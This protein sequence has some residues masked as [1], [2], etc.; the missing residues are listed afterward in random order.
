[1]RLKRLEITGFK[2]FARKSVFEF[3]AAVSSIVGPNGSGKS[4]VAES[5]RFVLGEQSMKSLRGKRGEDLIWN[6][7]GSMARG[8]VASVAIVFDNSTKEF[9]MDYDEVEIKRQVFRDGTN[10][11]FINGTQVRLKDILELLA[12]VHIGATGHHIISQGEADR[13][14]NANIKER[15]TMIEDA[16][17]LKIYQWKIEESEKKL[18]K[19]EEN[20]KQVESLRREIAPHIRFLKK[21]VEKIE[22]AKEMRDEL[23]ELYAEYLKREDV[24]INAE[25]ERIKL[26]KS[27][28]VSS[29]SVI[30]EKLNKA[31]AVLAAS[32]EHD[33]KKDELLRLE[34]EISAAR[35]G[36]DDAAR[37]ANR[38]DGMI[39]FE[40]RRLEKTRSR[41]AEAKFVSYTD[42]RSFTD[43]VEEFLKEGEKSDTLSEAR[44][45]FVK[46]RR[47]LGDFL[48]RVRQAGGGEPIADFSELSALKNEKK[49][50]E[51]SLVTATENES[52]LK[53]CYT[54]L[55]ESIEREKDSS[56][57]TER[58]VFEMMA[59]KS[60][61]SAVVSRLKDTE[62]N[63]EKA[64]RALK[65]EIKEGIVLVGRDIALY[66]NF[67]VS[68]DAVTGEPREEQEKRRRV[69]ERI[70]IKLEEQ[71][72]GGG[73]DIL[74]EYNDATERDGFLER[75]ITD[76]YQ[77]AESLRALIA[78]LNERLDTDFKE[79]IG[80]INKQFQEFF[81]LMFGG[82]T[83]S[84]FVVAQK[85][86]KRRD[87]DI[88]LKDDDEIVESFEEEI[89]E[90]IDINVSLPR[91]KIKGLQMLSGGERALTSIALIFAVSQVNPPPFL[92]LDETD[93]ALD[94]AN[95]RRYGDM[96]E[97]LSKHSQL[98]VITHNRETMSRAG[99]LYGVTMGSDA[100]S[101]LLS[102]RFD[103]A[104][105]FAK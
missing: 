15:R 89:E 58:A 83:A 35:A 61:L 11:Y 8:N 80:K 62:E 105:Q 26:E 81:A 85:K 34:S 65:E 66:E 63:I 79:G 72:V 95:S 51:E 28:P 17:G 39:E 90:G 43:E 68:R 73:E 42:V 88:V 1:M 76:L 40:E 96:L 50:A 12:K 49:K 3:N 23:K 13:I 67:A 31:R 70:K 74:K 64:D 46:A 84:L 59:K 56:R 45:F 25:K 52:R 57:E 14:L 55:K 103:E 102:V 97:N 30:E 54:A 93:A 38:L 32:D 36:K 33:P 94:E 21:Q 92:V 16:L 104:A 41:E 48:I 44:A 86:R 10:Q 2:S 6:G 9:E 37:Q 4:N 101:K 18:G 7:S 75:E 78:E 29:L 47:V 99:L 77:S 20:I 53:E 69:I 91:K 24:Y 5:I 98:I 27:G 19:T 71:G 87:T 100:V 60:E 82:G 22:K